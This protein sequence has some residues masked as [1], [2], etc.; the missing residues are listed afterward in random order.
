M[1]ITEVS[2]VLWVSEDVAIQISWVLPAGILPFHVKSLAWQ[3]LVQDS[4]PPPNY[5]LFGLV[6]QFTIQAPFLPEIKLF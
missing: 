2:K 4:V 6:Y 1:K 3:D 5:Q